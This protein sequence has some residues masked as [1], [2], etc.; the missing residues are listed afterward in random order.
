MKRVLSQLVSALCVVICVLAYV[1]NPQLF[2]A[3]TSTPVATS[4]SDSTADSTAPATASPAST[5][6]TSAVQMIDYNRGLK[7]AACDDDYRT[8]YEIFVS[9]FCDSNGDGVGDI[10]GVRQKLD[11]ITGLGFDQIWLTP[12]HPSA[13]YHKYDVD[14][15]CAIDPSLGT[16]EDYEALLEE[17]H[18]RGVR[19]LLDLVLNHTSDTH[20]WFVAAADYLRALPDGQDPVFE[21]CPYV[22]Y[23]TFSRERLN[24]FA[25]LEGTS[26]YYEARF[27]SEMPDL[28]LGNQVVRD[29]VKSIVQFWLAKGVDGFRLDAV[30]SYVTD[31]PDANVE[32]LRWLVDT[33]RS[34]DPD[35]Y[36]VGE[37]WT[38]RDAIAKLYTS[39]IDSLFDFP[40]ADSGGVIGQVMNGSRS[41]SDYVQAMVS[42]EGEYRAAY[43]DYV[44]APFYTNHDTAR[45]AAYY[46][47]DSGPATKM[48]YAMSLLMP[49]DSFVYYGEELGMEGAGKDENKRAPMRWSDD[50]Q[51]PGMC[52]GLAG[53]DDMQMKYPSLEEQMSDDLS[54]WR[55]FGEV[56][57]VRKAFPAIARGTTEPVDGVSDEN[58]AAFVRRCDGY[59][60]VLVVMNLR[61]EATQKDLSAVGGGLRLAAVLN[62]NTD[63]VTFENK[64]LTLPAY[65]IAVLSYDAVDSH[66]NS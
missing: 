45:S 3:M 59:E 9:S 8:T 47:Q 49:G 20:P 51:A 1:Q 43:P 7:P 65:S 66:T 5:T 19:V 13:T 37:A 40:F 36:L 57:R 26:W 2:E 6:P 62:T 41:A 18:G 32:F 64:T 46:P 28:N 54:L 21:D 11:Y 53:M 31:S 42:T 25:P 61:G 17:C 60:D 39:G 33:C 23:Y 35:C 34:I 24:G 29:E 14:D 63:A 10:N 38:D 55:W 56:I 16:M 50:V 58:V 52:A 48:A 27:W 22:W 15:Y 44:D 4:T 30:T 12:V